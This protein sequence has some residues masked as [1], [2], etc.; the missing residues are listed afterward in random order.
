MPKTNAKPKTDVTLLL[1][2]D[3][4]KVRN[5]FFDF[6]NEKKE[7]TKE[8]LVKQILTE[9]FIHATVEE[10][11]VYPCT[12][13]EADD[14]DDLLDEAETEHH[15]VKFLMAELSNMTAKDDQFEAKVTVLCE[16]VNHHV[17]EEEKEMFKKL[18]ESGADLE[19]LSEQVL[20]RKAQ[21]QQQPL[22][23][24]SSALSIG[25]KPAKQAASPAKKPLTN[26][27]RRVGRQ[28]RRSA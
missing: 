5:L 18:R 2:E 3:H 7:S 23:P 27:R 9:L 1:H 8:A 14:A 17:R 6:N 16:L 13:K 24:M 10:E 12:R 4:Q 11:I 21:L 25:K 26:G 28:Q 22:P 19:Q 15:V 20:A